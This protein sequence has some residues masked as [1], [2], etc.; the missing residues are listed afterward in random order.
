MTRLLTLIAFALALLPAT[1]GADAP[2]I[3]VDTERQ[4]LRVFEDGEVLLHV[5][6]VAIGRGGA[7]RDRQ[8]GDGTT[9][10][11]EFRVAW[12]NE[13]SRFHRFF[14]FDFPTFSHARR[15]Y[16]QG[17]MEIDEFL[18]VTD[19]LRARR[20]P[21]QRTTLGGHLGIHGLGPGDDALHRRSNW[22]N[23][24]I[25][26]TDEEMNQLSEY[27]RVGTRVVVTADEEMTARADDS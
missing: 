22:T 11:G 19:A 13:D 7:S 1:A 25:A 27:V 26:V 23:G 14:G 16:N 6:R 12:V 17:V 20:L 10:I 9:P 2:W 3:H 5:P 15:A 4:E 21:P 18:E 24:C 8:R